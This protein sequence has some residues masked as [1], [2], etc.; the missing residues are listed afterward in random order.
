MS[1]RD[2]YDKEILKQLTKIANALEG[3]KRLLNND[4]KSDMDSS[5][6]IH[7]SVPIKE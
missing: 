2:N 5:N 7:L 4:Q 3:I 1:N 6:D